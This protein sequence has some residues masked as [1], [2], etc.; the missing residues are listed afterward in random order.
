M[1][2]YTEAFELPLRFQDDL[3][4]YQDKRDNSACIY[5]LNHEKTRAFDF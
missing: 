3:Y 2:E 4:H 5:F 1:Y